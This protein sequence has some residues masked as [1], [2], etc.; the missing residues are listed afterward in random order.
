MKIKT[1]HLWFVQFTLRSLGGVMERD[2]HLSTKTDDEETA[3]RLASTIMDEECVSDWAIED[4]H[5]QYVGNVKTV[6]GVDV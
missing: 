5:I 3:H 1:K 4:F 6:K 2:F